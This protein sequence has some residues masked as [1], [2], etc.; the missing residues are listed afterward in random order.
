MDFVLGG[1]TL[2]LGDDDIVLGERYEVT[3][4]E[5]YTDSRGKRIYAGEMECQVIGVEPNLET[6]EIKLRLR[7]IG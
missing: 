3:R 5:A 6:D 7:K 2:L 1:D 4:T